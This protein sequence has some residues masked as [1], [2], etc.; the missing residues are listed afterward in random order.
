MQ[1]VALLLVLLTM[2]GV[3]GSQAGAPADHPFAGTWTANLA[4]SK[5]HSNAQ[6]QRIT[7]RFDLSADAVSITDMVID[8]SGRNVGNGTTTFQ[9]DGKAY[10]HDELLPG[11]TVVARWRDSRAF[12]TV[13]SRRDGQMDRVTYEISADG[14]TLTNTTSGAL[15]EQVIVFER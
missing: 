13:L 6:I 8:V 11:L 12:E 3:G 10:P 4:K 5:L 9:T 14:M 15:G 7:L 1:N 2:T